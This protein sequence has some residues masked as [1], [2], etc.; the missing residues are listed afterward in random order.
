MTPLQFTDSQ[1]NMEFFYWD[2]IY[3]KYRPISILFL[4]ISEQSYA[5]FDA[6]IQ[7]PRTDQVLEKKQITRLQNNNN[8]LVR[9]HF[10]VILINEQHHRVQDAKIPRKDTFRQKKTSLS[11]SVIT[12]IPGKPTP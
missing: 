2:Q 6:A 4:G 10:L 1:I 7:F 3:I 8:N 5:E 12:G 9:V 11:T